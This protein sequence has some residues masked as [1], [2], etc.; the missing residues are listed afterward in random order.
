MPVEDEII[1]GQN[2]VSGILKRLKLEREKRIT[3]EPMNE[4]EVQVFLD[5]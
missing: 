4:Q 2:P 3:V 5:I 1:P